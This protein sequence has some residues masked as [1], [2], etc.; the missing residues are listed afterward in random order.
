MA[1]TKAGAA[2]ATK[3]MY[4]KYGEN[5]FRRVGKI[6]GQNGHTGGLYNNPERAKQLGSKGGS[7]SKRGKTF[8]REENGKRIYLDHTTNKVEEYEVK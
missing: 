2:K 4:E 8:I 5:F 7:V 3:T 1:Q 6:G